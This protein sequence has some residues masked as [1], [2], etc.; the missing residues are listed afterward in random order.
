MG[1]VAQKFGDDLDY[2][3]GIELYKKLGDFVNSNEP[4]A[5]IFGSNKRK[6]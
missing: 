5:R 1:C 3:A 2:S 4:I 6:D